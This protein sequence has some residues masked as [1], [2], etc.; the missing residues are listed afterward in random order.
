MLHCLAVPLLIIGVPFLGWMEMEFDVH[1]YLAAFAVLS[2]VV[3]LIPGYLV[4]RR[5]TV[6]LGGIAGMALIIS[7]AWVIA[8]YFGE[9]PE[10]V[11]TVAGAA[12]LFLTHFKNQRHCQA[13]FNDKALFLQQ[14]CN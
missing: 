2:V 5:H 7:G 11:F 10:A 12:V 1:R 13:C 8:P 14:K 9:A 3:A 6:L 4:H